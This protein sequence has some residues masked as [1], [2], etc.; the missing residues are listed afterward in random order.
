MNGYETQQNYDTKSAAWFKKHIEELNETE[1]H[2]LHRHMG[3]KRLKSLPS[4]K[5]AQVNTEK[6]EPS[7]IKNKPYFG[8]VSI[9]VDH[10]LQRIKHILPTPIQDSQEIKRLLQ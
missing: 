7:S 3:K 9:W 10:K 2:F 6:K 4:N 8:K 5:G 1:I